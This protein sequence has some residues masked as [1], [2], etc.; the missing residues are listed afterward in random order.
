LGAGDADWPITK[1]S[2]FAKRNAWGTVLRNE[3]NLPNE[4]AWGTVLR[5]EANFA[6]RNGWARV[7]RSEA[8]LPN[9]NGVLTPGDTKCERKKTSTQVSVIEG[10]PPVTDSKRAS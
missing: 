10:Y 3:A 4:M 2:Q 6:K 5:N 9:E 7:L 1:R 8:N